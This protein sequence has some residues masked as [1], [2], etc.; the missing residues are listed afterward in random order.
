MKR[1]GQ[2]AAAHAG[3]GVIIVNRDTDEVIEQ[4]PPWPYIGMTAE[5]VSLTLA[6]IQR[7][8]ELLWRQW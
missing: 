7:C 1:N 6:L 5:Y 2:R 3:E 8:G 4:L